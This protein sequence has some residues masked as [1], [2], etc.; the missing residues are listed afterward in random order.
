M[1]TKIGEGYIGIRGDRSKLKG[2]L[3]KAEREFKTGASR[4]KKIVGGISF[5]AA[6]YGTARL[7]NA[8]AEWARM[9]GVQQ[10]AVAGLDQAMRSMGRYSTDLRGR[11]LD[12]ARALQEVTTFGDE[13]T[14]AGTK[15][16][17]TYKDI[18]D[19][20]LP[21]AQ[22]TMLDL[23]ELMGGDT[24]QAANMLGKASMGLAGEL[25]RVGITIDEDVAHAGDFSK[26]LE[27]IAKQ[28]GGQARAAAE[29]GIGP[30]EQ[31]A[32]IWGDAKED[33]GEL[34][35]TIGQEII[36]ALRDM[37]A[38]VSRLAQEMNNVMSGDRSFWNFLMGWDEYKAKQASLE[39]EIQARVFGKG[40][41]GTG[42]ADIAGL[43]A[44]EAALTGGS[45]GARG[46]GGGGTGGGEGFNPNGLPLATGWQGGGMDA[47]AIEMQNAA[48]EREMEFQA[49]LGEIKYDSIIKEKE[50]KEA[51]LAEDIERMNRENAAVQKM[52]QQKAKLKKQSIDQMLGDAAY[53]FQWAGKQNE[54]AFTAF[55][56]ISIAET[57]IKTIEAAQKAYAW[58]S[59]WGGPPAGAGAA[60]LAAAAGFARVA[61]IQGIEPGGG[62]GGGVSGG[63]GAVGTYNASPTTGL[64]TE[65]GTDKAEQSVNVHIHL[66]DGLE[67]QRVAEISAAL[68]DWVEARGG[69]LVATELN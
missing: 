59:S 11:L 21:K 27:E 39:A 20:V 31:L 60:A 5:A 65:T 3:D 4:M 1:A 42:G 53:F 41:A 29:T 28:V 6:I 9:A 64:P 34:A 37:T 16:L 32:N 30:W 67:D 12:N 68:T 63:G 23:A 25:R 50:W 38:E 56:A 58:A 51:A 45:G 61:Q 35:L 22:E 48:I 14:I 19:D 47:E 49:Q 36:P 43:A 26:I 7:V 2:D 54:M 52:E 57:S 55:K 69:R 24:Q 44:A 8:G 33:L 62:G 46:P 40:A 18:G 10:K 17:L 66:E 13:A 15:F